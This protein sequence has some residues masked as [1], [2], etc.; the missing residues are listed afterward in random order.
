VLKHK[1]K[2]PSVKVAKKKR[3]DWP[4]PVAPEDAYV[5]KEKNPIHSILTA[6]PVIMLV[7][8]LYSYYQGESEQT[9]S[10]PILEH[11]QSIEGTFTGFSVVKSG[12][13]GRHYLW[14]DSDGDPRGFRIRPEHRDSLEQL[15]KG[16]Q[17][18]L[19]VAPT[20]AGSRVFWAWRVSQSGK[21]LL[22]MSGQIR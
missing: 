18:R 9:E 19:D 11:S 6:L 15:H 12:A 14:I 21:L 1:P 3:Y 8:G 22:D 4:P 13:V 17:T 10:L 7:V 5:A 2:S 20:V 16:E